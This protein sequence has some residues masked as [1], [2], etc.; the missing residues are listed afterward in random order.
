ME[1]IRPGFFENLPKEMKIEMRQVMENI[2]NKIRDRFLMF[3]QKGIEEGIITK[4]LDDM[5]IFSISSLI[6]GSIMV[7]S[8]PETNLD[9]E[10]VVD[11]LYQKVLLFSNQS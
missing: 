8:D 1:A 5:D 7:Y 9:L 6:V 10:Q 11:T 4:P 3:F 2:R